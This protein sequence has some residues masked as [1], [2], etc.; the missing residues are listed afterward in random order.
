TATCPLTTSRHPTRPLF[1]YT[2]L[3]RSVGE[4]VETRI[5]HHQQVVADLVAHGGER[6]VEDPVR[7][8]AA[9]AGGV[10]VLVPGDAE[11]HDP[12]EPG[13][14]GGGGLSAQRVDGVLRDPGKGGDR[15]R[16]VDP[17][18][19]ERREDQLL[20]AEGGLGHQP[21]HRG[22]RTQATGTDYGTGLS[23][24]GSQGSRGPAS[25]AAGPPAGRRQL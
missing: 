13:L 4:L 6:P 21:A 15:P 18:G 1:P 14:R 16:L 23:T 25:A 5:R 19:D 8:G 7:R 11:Q 24:H 2:T 3:F 20:R 22:G 12:A 10:L 9:T 17:V